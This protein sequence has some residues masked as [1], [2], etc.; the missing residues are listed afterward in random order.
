MTSTKIGRVGVVEIGLFRTLG[1]EEVFGISDVRVTEI[2]AYC[3]E[4]FIIFKL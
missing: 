4:I 3:F 2:P 1:G